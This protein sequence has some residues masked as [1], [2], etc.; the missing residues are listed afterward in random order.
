MTYARAMA[1]GT[2]AAHDSSRQH[3]L[4]ATVEQYEAAN[5]ELKASKEEL[6]SMNEEMR[7]SSEELE[8]SKEELQSVNEELTTVNHQLKCRV[9]ELSDTNTDLSNLMASTDIGTIFFGPATAHPALHAERAK[10]FQSHRGGHGTPALRHHAQA[11]R[12]KF[13]RR[14]R[15][16]PARLDHG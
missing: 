3:Q 1:P 15:A 5:E 14:H 9:E 12:Q 6:Q 16:G 13:P 10:D 7:S 11:R 4:A 8:T 2:V